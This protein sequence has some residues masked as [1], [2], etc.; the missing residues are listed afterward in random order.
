MQ[1]WL[2]NTLKGCFKIKTMAIKRN[3]FANAQQRTEP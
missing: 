3:N 2:E 1:R